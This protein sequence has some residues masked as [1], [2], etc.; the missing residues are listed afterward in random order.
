MIIAH[1]E[2]R[3]IAHYLDGSLIKG[4][5]LDFFPTKDRFHIAGENGEVNEVYLDELKAVFFVKDFDGN[6][7]YTE[8]K[9]FF[10]AVNQGKKVMVEFKDGEVIF[11]SALAKQAEAERER[12]A[13]I[14]HAEGEFQASE[15]LFQAANI[16]SQNPTTLQLR[17]LQTLT[18]VAVEKNSTIVFPIPIDLIEPLIETLKKAG[19]TKKPPGDA[20]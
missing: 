6:S 7:D 3:V 1:R 2:N 9:G 18:E 10:N 14:I 17:Y 15:K 20:A 16:I 5:T 11:G 4:T 12:R 8:K 13:K 19:K